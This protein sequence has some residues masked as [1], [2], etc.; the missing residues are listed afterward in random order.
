MTAAIILVLALFMIVVASCVGI[1][2]GWG[3]E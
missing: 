3:M 2:I 1:C